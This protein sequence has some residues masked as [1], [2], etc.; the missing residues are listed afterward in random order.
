MTNG[1]AGDKPRLIWGKKNM[2]FL[3]YSLT[4]GS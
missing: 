1:M 3:A 2:Q 4:E